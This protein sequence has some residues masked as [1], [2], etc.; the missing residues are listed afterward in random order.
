[1]VAASLYIPKNNS[2]KPLGED[3]HFLYESYQTIGVADGVGGWAKMGIDAG[4]YARKL[5]RN[6]LIATNNE[7]KGHV[8]PKRV[9]QEAYKNTSFEGS[10]TACIITLDKET[11]IV[12]A[13]NVGA[14]G[15]FLIRKGKVIYKSPI[16]QR[17]FGCPY[18]LGKCKDNPSV[19]HEMELIVEKDD[20]LIVGTD[21]ML[22]NMNESE[23]EKIIRKGIDR[24][25]KAEELV[26][27]I[28]KAALY[29]SFNRFADTPYARA[30]KRE[31]LSQTQKGGKIN[32]ITVIVAYIN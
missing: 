22:D 9:L 26:R 7:P 30:A 27:K 23:I 15:F 16:Q 24:K 12:Y 4:I 11:N 19:A 5:M 3:A 18:Q 13:A 8:N 20:I 21:G 1:M 14:S 2:K 31:G 10:S 25:L 32:D 29:N 17:G 6:S 28:G